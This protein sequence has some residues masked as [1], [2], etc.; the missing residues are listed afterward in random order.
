MAKSPVATER[1]PVAGSGNAGSARV[2]RFS[3]GEVAELLGSLRVLSEGLSKTNP[4][5]RL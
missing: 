2:R 1:V 5:G 3:V 4:G